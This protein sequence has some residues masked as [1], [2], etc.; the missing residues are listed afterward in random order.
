M[1]QKFLSLSIV[2]RPPSGKSRKEIVRESQAKRRAKQGGVT[3]SFQVSKS[4]HAKLKGKAKGKK[5]TLTFFLNQALA[6]IASD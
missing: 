3:I 5:V 2:G 6:Q 4:L 1:N